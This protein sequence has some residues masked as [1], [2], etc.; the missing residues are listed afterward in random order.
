MRTI[1]RWN[2]LRIDLR[3][4]AVLGLSL[5]LVACNNGGTPAY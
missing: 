3:V 1:A 5:L 2:L 4:V